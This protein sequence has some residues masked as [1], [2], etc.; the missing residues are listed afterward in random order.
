[1]RLKRVFISTLLFFIFINTTYFWEGQ[2]GFFAFPLFL[3][4][5]IAYIGLFIAF[6]GQ[7]YLVIKEKFSNTF[8]LLTVSLLITVMVLTYF[9]PNGLIDFDKF[10]GKDILIAQREGAA[11]CMTTIKLKDNFTFKERSVCFGVTEIKGDYRFQ[12]DTIYFDN[13]ETGRNKDKYYEFAVIK[14][15]KYDKEK[16]Q[17]ELVRFKSLKDTIGHELWITKNELNKL[18]NKKP[19]R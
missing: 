11:N 17:F 10:Q 1:M 14:P 18:K 4:L 8:R 9:K 5:V 7:F 6:I 2:L 19:T 13:V 3:I 12:N 15:S 16:K